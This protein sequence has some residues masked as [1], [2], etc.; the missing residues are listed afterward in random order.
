M[1]TRPQPGVAI[2]SLLAP[3]PKGGCQPKAD[4]GIPH[5]GG[6][7]P[8]SSFRR[9]VGMPPY[10]CF[11]FSSTFRMAFHVAWKRR[12]LMSRKS[13]IGVWVIIAAVTIFSRYAAGPP[14]SMR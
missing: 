11:R 2:R 5:R 1:R 12:R 4:W 3:L 6:C 7:Q 14:G 8:P 9:H 10:F 13:G